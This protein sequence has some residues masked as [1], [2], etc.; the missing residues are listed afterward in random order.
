MNFFSQP[1]WKAVEYEDSDPLLSYGPGGLIKE[2]NKRV[3]IESVLREAGVVL[4]GRA[5]VHCPWTHLHSD[6]SPAFKIFYHTNTG[7]CFSCQKTYS[8]VR[9]AS[10]VWDVNKWEAAEKLLELVGWTPESEIRNRQ[11]QA[12]QFSEELIYDLSGYAELLRRHC[13]VSNPKEK[14]YP[15][16]E[17]KE[18]LDKCMSLLDSAKTYSDADIWLKGCREY[19][20]RRMKT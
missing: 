16:F 3:L 2:A 7:R 19:M 14:E 18:D 1:E 12:E 20:D 10:E 4:T 5:K 11:E 9:L 15:D 8:P 13:K 6:N 17:Y